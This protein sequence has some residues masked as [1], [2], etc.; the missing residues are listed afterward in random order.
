M[1]AVRREE[2]P[3]EVGVLI[4]VLHVAG[5]GEGDGDALGSHHRLRE[6]VVS[7]DESG[8]MAEPPLDPHANEPVGRTAGSDVH[9]Q[10]V[11][12]PLEFRLIHRWTPCR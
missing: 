12:D 1:P 4:D 8:M 10:V 11:D 2:L 9:N 5:A 7:R 6:S 3:E